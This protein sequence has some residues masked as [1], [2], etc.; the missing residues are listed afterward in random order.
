MLIRLLAESESINMSLM[1]P[2]MLTEITGSADVDRAHIC[3]SLI[4]HQQLLNW[5]ASHVAVQG[6]AKIAMMGC[7]T[8]AN[9]EF[10]SGF[11]LYRCKLT[12]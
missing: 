3:S 11:P 5:L 6:F 9:R 10:V 2:S 12:N 7:I 1:T 8:K 4:R